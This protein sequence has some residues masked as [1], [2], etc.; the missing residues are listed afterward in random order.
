EATALMATVEGI[1]RPA[2]LPAQSRGAIVRTHLLPP[3]THAVYERAATNPA[4]SNSAVSYYLQLCETTDDRTRVVAVLF[5][6]IAREPCFDT[7]RTKEQLGYIVFSHMKRQTGVEA[8]QVVVQSE[9]APGAVGE[10][11]AAF[12]ASM[13]PRLA[14]MPDADLARHRA[15]VAAAFLEKD[16]NLYGEA[17]RLWQHVAAR[18]YDFGIGP[19]TAAEVQLVTRDDLLA[20]YDAHVAPEAAGARRLC[21]HV[22][23]PAA[24]AATAAA[25][26][27]VDDPA[28]RP[29]VLLRSDDDV[30][31]FKA[32]LPLGRA[33]VSAAPLADL[34]RREA[35]GAA[36]ASR[37]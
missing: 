10:R 31:A 28:A 30:A 2:S 11:V 26:A 17:A 21:V 34:R 6:Q 9:R 32:A 19:R 16:K 37:I 36:P 23:S 1:L 24:A 15:A 7:L 35:A 29:T 22:V 27:S 3:G 13:R 33:P 14:D 5:A 4:E 12:L 25:G 18:S 20:F 8:F